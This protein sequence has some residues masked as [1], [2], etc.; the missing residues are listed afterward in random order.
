MTNRSAPLVRALLPI[1]FLAGPIAAFGALGEEV[2]EREPIRWDGLTASLMGD[3]IHLLRSFM[4]LWSVVGGGYGL[5]L[6]AAVVLGWLAV[7]RRFADA[8]FVALSVVGASLLG[9]LAK[10]IFDR[11]RPSVTRYLFGAD[12][13]IV[14]IA[15]VILVAALA[16]SPR[17]RGLAVVTAASFVLLIGL[18]LVV[19]VAVRT[20]PTLDSFPS[21]HAVSS[22][23]FAVAVVV[24]WPE[25]TRWFATIVASVFVFVVGLSRVYLG[26][27]Y[28]SDVLGGWC[29][30]LAWVTLLTL[31]VRPR[32]LTASATLRRRKEQP[33]E[34]T[35]T[36]S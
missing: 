33:V 3:R 2:S 34:E 15:A 35:H 21:G 32:L 31:A 14:A 9:R 10:A 26:F 4:A 25:R 16:I 19:D 29:L 6:L 8:G 11:P 12:P 20:P 23:A 18:D 5:I 17:R 1:A 13:T 30:S 27:H 7:R 28:P 24:I 22:M 36:G